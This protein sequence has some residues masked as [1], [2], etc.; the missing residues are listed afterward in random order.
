MKTKYN[1]MSFKHS[2]FRSTSEPGGKGTWPMSCQSGAFPTKFHEA[3]CD[4]KQNPESNVYIAQA[5]G[6]YNL[7]RDQTILVGFH[8]LHTVAACP[9]L[10]QPSAAAINETI[11]TVLNKINNTESDLP[12]LQQSSLP[13]PSLTFSGN[14]TTAIP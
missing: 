8:E 5:R 3:R 4:R 11:D 7:G 13:S 10:R 2:G 1:M 14:N 12:V 9:G 6:G